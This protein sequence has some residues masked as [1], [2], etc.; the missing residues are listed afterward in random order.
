MGPDNEKHPIK[1]KVSNILLF[2]FSGLWIEKSKIPT[3]LLSGLLL[4][5]H[6]QGLEDQAHQPG[7]HRR[8]GT[9]RGKSIRW[10]ARCDRHPWVSRFEI[11]I[12]A[13]WHGLLQVFLFFW[14]D[15]HMTHIYFICQTNP[16]WGLSSIQAVIPESWIFLGWVERSHLLWSG[17][18]LPYVSRNCYQLAVC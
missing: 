12:A 15:A 2:S 17:W 5:L 13:V 10:A 11:L 4:D 1:T 14:I 7:Q 6:R 9:C 18:L 3:R 16:S 8:R